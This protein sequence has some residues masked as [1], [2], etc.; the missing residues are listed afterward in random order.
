MV[1]AIASQKIQPPPENPGLVWDV[2]ASFDRFNISSYS[3][4]GII[5][6]PSFPADFPLNP[7]HWSWKS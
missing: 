1:V 2:G 3:T 6:K 7:L 5:W 4:C